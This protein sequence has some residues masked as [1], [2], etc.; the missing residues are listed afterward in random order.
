MNVV[1]IEPFFP[2]TQRN[3]VRGLAEAG[4]T[5][6]GIGESPPEMLDD[7]L[8]SWMTHYHQVPTV[9]DVGIL[10]D[11]VRWVQ[12]KLWVDRLESTIEAHTL[13]A[14]QAR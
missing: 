14:A 5:V 3:F 2:S 7:Q 4:A 11:T 1:F 6:I 13:A 9:I 12:D 10:T 8:K